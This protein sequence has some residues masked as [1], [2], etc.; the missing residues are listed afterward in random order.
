M[1]PSY[2]EVVAGLTG[3]GG[4]FEIVTE[5]ALGRP[6][7]TFKNRERSMR[8]KVANCGLRGD[9]DFLVQ[10]DRRVSYAEFARGVWGAA[11][12]LERDHGMK[13]GDRLAILSYNCPDWLIALF[14]ATSLGGVAV[15]LNGWWA[16]EEIDYGL[17]DSGSRFLVVDERL[18]PRVEPLP[19]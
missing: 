6:V 12:S 11:R 1:A 16:T 19:S 5:T 10:G 15:G 18:Y 2:E 13:P 9:I 14:G 17:K 7:K 4:P 8:E 3:P